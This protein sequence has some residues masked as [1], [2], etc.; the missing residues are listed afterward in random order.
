MGN[1][2]KKLDGSALEKVEQGGNAR[3][4]LAVYEEAYGPLTAVDT[5]QQ[6]AYAVPLRKIRPD[7]AQPRRVLPSE[8][9]GLEPDALFAEWAKRA[10]TSLAGVKGLYFVHS[11]ADE[12][13][14]FQF[15]DEP[16]GFFDLVALAADIYRNGGL[17]NPIT[18][19]E[20]TRN[21]YQ[22]E[23][24]ERRYWA[25][26]LLYLLMS[27]DRWLHIA[28]RIVEQHSVWRQAGENSHRANLGAVARARQ[29]A[30]LVMDIYRQKGVEFQTFDEMV[31]PGGCDRTFYAQVGDGKDF[32][33][34]GNNER[35]MAAMGEKDKSNLR[36]LRRGLNVTDKVWE[37]AE[38]ENWPLGRL[39][40]VMIDKPKPRKK[41]VVITTL[42]DVRTLSPP[43]IDA[44]YAD[45]Q[46]QLDEK[47]RQLDSLFDRKAVA[48]ND[49]IRENLSREIKVL[50]AEISGLDE[51][52]GAIKRAIVGKL[53]WPGSGQLP[54]ISTGWE[55]RESTGARNAVQAPLSD[56]DVD[57]QPGVIDETATDAV[58]D[59]EAWSR[60][61]S[62]LDN[63]L[64]PDALD[65]L[66]EINYRNAVD[67]LGLVSHYVQMRMNRTDFEPS[68]PEGLMVDFGR[69]AHFCIQE[70]AR[71]QGLRDG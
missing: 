10:D 3:S 15:P 44:H 29:F 45:Y 58:D 69:L 71:L 39:Q 53:S 16:S 9:R 49:L 27:E 2:R 26:W 32:S 63:E 12:D 20:M 61:V 21:G 1:R 33:L 48:Q 65:P 40:Q 23:T 55:S 47:E 62:M 57:T 66:N 8:L 11:H 67:A 25:F 7:P 43:Q 18:I 4:N 24:G 68:D 50:E 37:Q 56:P 17:T 52:Y 6:V 59:D 38:A 35:V 30:L 13:E 28:A 54:G 51:A 60:F 22:I 31:P 14:N 42:P 36:H 46:R 70:M 19:S 34:R 41:S 64:L 5:D